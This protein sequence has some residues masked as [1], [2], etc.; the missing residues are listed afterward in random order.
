MTQKLCDFVEADVVEGESG[1][2]GLQEIQKDLCI[3]LMQC[4]ERIEGTYRSME[5]TGDNRG[6]TVQPHT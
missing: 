1:I 6:V 5:E 2:Y 3:L 4:Q